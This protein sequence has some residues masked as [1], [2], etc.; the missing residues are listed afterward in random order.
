MEELRNIIREELQ[1]LIFENRRNWSP[2]QKL[3]HDH[4]MYMDD[5]FERLETIRKI[6][7]ITM[8]NITCQEMINQII[9]LTW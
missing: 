4:D 7:A 2:L 3:K 5:A 6:R 9:P 1:Q 8:R